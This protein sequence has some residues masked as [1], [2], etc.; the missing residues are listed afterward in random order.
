M[1]RVILG[2]VATSLVTGLVLLPVGP[3]TA[4]KIVVVN[5]YYGDTPFIYGGYSYI[6]IRNVKEALGAALL[7][8]SLKQRAVLTYN[9]HELGLVVGSPVVHLD[10]APVSFP[11]APVIVNNYVFVPVTTIRRCLNVPVEYDGKKR[12]VKIRGP[13]HWSVFTVN[14]HPKSS[15]V[16]KL[17]RHEKQFG[18]QKKHDKEDKSQGKGG[19]AKG[20]KK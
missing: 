19:K 9:G 18:A 13:K 16:A 14:P 2:L 3:A 20:K 5:N 12:E 11:V 7:W 1:K 8:D 17:K 15:I 6:P 10:G 4:D